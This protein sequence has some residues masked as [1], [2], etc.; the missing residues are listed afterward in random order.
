KLKRDA[1]GGLTIH[2]QPKSPGADLE[3][4]WLPSPEGPFWIALRLYWP[5]AEALERK[6]LAPALHKVE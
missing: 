6:W 2:V 5:K 3:S 4:N 1:D